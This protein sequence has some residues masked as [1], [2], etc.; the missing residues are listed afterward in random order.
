MYS[1]GVLTY[2][3]ASL[4]MLKFM[5]RAET[6][7]THTNIQKYKYMPSKYMRLSE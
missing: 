2:V 4:S 7:E 5:K 6:G 1:V 3:Y